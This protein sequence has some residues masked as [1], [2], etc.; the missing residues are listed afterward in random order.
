MEI[1]ITVKSIWVASEPVDFRKSIDGLQIVIVD[2]LKQNP[3]EGVFIFYNRAR[4]KIKM[5][6]P[7]RRGH[8]LLYK[9]FDQ[10]KLKYQIDAKQKTLSIDERQLSWLLAGLEWQAMSDCSDLNFDD[11]Y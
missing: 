11:Y 4:N 2:D 3:H 10:G 8:L 5:I 7:H 9:R 1:K 6:L